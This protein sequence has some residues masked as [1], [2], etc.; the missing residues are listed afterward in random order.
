MLKYNKQWP[1]SKVS[2]GFLVFRTAW[3]QDALRWRKK[4]LHVE[5]GYPQ[6]NVSQIWGPA[7]IYLF[8][9]QLLDVIETWFWCL[10]IYSECQERHWKYFQICISSGHLEI[11]D[12]RFRT[13]FSFIFVINHFRNFL[14]WAGN[15]SNDSQMCYKWRDNH[16]CLW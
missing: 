1:I 15:T 10:N 4:W 16:L 5:Q 11:Q 6:R 8:I 13:L 14:L 7:N 12:G 2:S 3:C 9:S